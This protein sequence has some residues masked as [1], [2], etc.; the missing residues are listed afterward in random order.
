M[1]EDRAIAMFTDRQNVIVQTHKWKDKFENFQLSLGGYISGVRFNYGFRNDY[2]GQCW[3]TNAMSEAMWGIYAGDS[4]LKYLRLRSTPR[5]LLEALEK[6]HAGSTINDTCFVG[7]VLYK[8]ENEL[9]ASLG[10]GGTLTLS[11]ASLA[12]SLLLKRRAFKH[13]NEMRL[14]YCTHNEA[15]VSNGL[16]RYPIDPQDMITQIMADPHRDPSSWENE[17]KRLQSETGF[18]GKILRSRMY[19]PP[20]W[21]PPFYT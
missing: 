13:E 8:K 10:A 21:A 11:S 19:D 4:Q 17:R 6:A 7:R 12:G 2:L 5:K 18:K 16:Y 20:K 9:K 14:I 1:R 15:G 3:T